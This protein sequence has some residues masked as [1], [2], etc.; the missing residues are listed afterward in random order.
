VGLAPTIEHAAEQQPPGSRLRSFRSK[1]SWVVAGLSAAL[2][3]APLIAAAPAQA[4]PVHL[5]VGLF[6]NTEPTYDGVFRQSLAILGLHAAGVTPRP[7]AVSWLLR[8]QCGDGGFSS[9]NPDTSKSCPV[10]N[11]TD[12]TGGEDTN[13][14]ALAVQALYAVG[15]DSEAR[16]AATWLKG[17]Q[18]SDGGWEYTAKSG[19]GSDPNST[20]LVLT[21]LAAA[22]LTPTSS[23][24][25][26]FA[27]L[28]V[29]RSNFA[30]TDPTDRGGFDTPYSNGVP[31]VLG[32]VQAIPG[33][34]GADLLITPPGGT[35]WQDS[36]DAAPSS[37]PAAT[38]AGI[39]HWATTWLG[40]QVTA[41]NV[42]GSNASWAI[43]S[44][45][46]DHKGEDVA[47]TLYDNVIKGNVPVTNPGA[48]GLGALS[49][50][51]LRRDADVQTY[52]TNIEASLQKDP[53]APNATWKKSLYS[54]WSGQSVTLTRLSLSDNY[55]PTSA[56]TQVINWG[57]GLQQSVSSTTRAVTHN[58]YGNVTRTVTV[59]ITDPS[60]NSRALN[61][62]TVKVIADDAAPAMSPIRPANPTRVAS[63]KTLQFKASDTISGVR[64]VRVNVREKRGSVWYQYNGASWSKVTTKTHTQYLAATKSGSTW[65][66]KNVKGLTKGYLRLIYTAYDGAGNRCATAG[67]TQLLSR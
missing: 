36:T 18:N 52:A 6:G 16:A 20:G 10:F 54:V 60:G 27:G 38:V 48:N 53:T 39:S 58:Y 1:R 32:T 29:G 49:A 37:V 31:D 57:D 7:E 5:E 13:A 64:Y 33:L 55:W 14:T 23:A 51:T 26:Y 56:L 22:G 50:A 34:V 4:S 40:A 62:G 59:K 45:G 46:W 30:G 12:F 35:A 11:S 61:L 65:V 9:Y 28:Q 17:L 44:F 3:A 67:F 2:L 15:A 21:G 41:N 43:L 8:Q 19:S 24:T 25:A 66:I 42:T 63:W 47:N